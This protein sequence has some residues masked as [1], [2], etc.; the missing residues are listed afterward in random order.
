MLKI[1]TY[2]G[3]LAILLATLLLCGCEPSK[4]AVPAVI[5][6]PKTAA[7]TP[8]EKSVLPVAGATLLDGFEGPE[9]TLWAFDSAD[10]EG[11]AQY[12]E[13]GATQGKKA[14][15]IALQGKGK[16]GRLHLRRDV[17]L[18]LSHA[19]AILLD[20]TSPADDLSM[21][22]AFKGSPDD[23]YQ[24]SMPVGL[25]E[26]LNRD[27]RIPLDENNW[28]NAESKWNFSGPPVNLKFI[29]RVM[30]YL[31]TGNESSG[32]FLVDNLRIEGPATADASAQSGSLGGSL[33]RDWRPEILIAPVV[34]MAAVQYQ[35]LEFQTVFRASYRDL[36]D[37]NDVTLGMRVTT[38]SGKNFEIR[39][40]FGGLAHH[41][42]K[43][44][45]PNENAALEPMW[46]PFAGSRKKEWKDGKQKRGNQKKS[47]NDT[48]KQSPAPDAKH[49]NEKDVNGG[50]NSKPKEAGDKSE[51]VKEDKPKPGEEIIP[52]WMLRFTPQETGR[53]TLQT[54][55]RNSVGEARL[56]EQSMVVAPENSERA[57]PGRRGGNVRVSKR[58]PRQLELQDGSPFYCFG[59]NV[60]WTKN[61]TPYLEKIQTYG[62]NTCRIW[63]CPWG[64]SLE[65][66]AEPGS[67][68]PKEAARLDALLEQA[69]A[70]GVRIVFCFT[71][72]GATRD[73]WNDSPYNQMNGGPCA[74]GQEFFSDWRAKRQFK[75]LL[76]YAA[77]RWG[78]SPALLSW[79]LINE[80][81]LANYDNPEDVAGWVREMAGHL[82]AVD[83]HGHLVTTS[84]SN[85]AFLPELWQD[86]RLDLV[87]L[88]GYGTDV[89]KLLYEHLAPYQVLHKPL[90]LAEFGGGTEPGDDIPDKDGAR[91]QAGLW[92]TACSPSC[93]MALPWWWD[94]YI[95]ARNLYPLFSAAGRFVANDDRRGRF[96]DWVR[97]SY[98]GGVQVNGI[99]DSQ[100]AR[101]YV[102]RPEWTRVPESRGGALIVAALPLELTGMLDGAYKIE[103][104]DAKEGKVFSTQEAAVSDGKLLLQLP[105]HA[106]EFALKIERKE[107]QSPGLK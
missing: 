39:G 76:S 95:E 105:A 5:E 74:R 29:K 6:L 84:V 88:H 54:Y 77:A 94:T 7:S 64:L 67:F 38:P 73:M 89:S 98:D 103:F 44:T 86:H 16:T 100:G 85:P 101:L 20:I 58:D 40:F 4:P 18:N 37:S 55:V 63:L 65:R 99:M 12:V 92:L 22:L 41:Q 19:R 83:V 51:A 17:E 107:H 28:K 60:C 47:E 66:K 31:S 14:L 69:E 27:V 36:Y 45:A 96:T 42:G 87:C 93:G 15:R 79:E 56:P 90:L 10:D 81:D 1:L 34:P 8:D 35:G 97:K 11:I 72:H 24:E 80:M 62:G 50:T 21:A 104:W 3:H 91:L 46:G 53:Y 2:H 82:K 106:A 57:A 32:N 49:S 13:E 71:F 78:A 30:I 26:G 59:Q 61:W 70:T 9:H 25:K 102:H 75:R 33:Y 43:L 23:L 48:P 68:D 52:V